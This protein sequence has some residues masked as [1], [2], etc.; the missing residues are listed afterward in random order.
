MFY[1]FVDMVDLVSFVCR[2]YNLHRFASFEEFDSVYN[3]LKHWHKFS[4]YDITWKNS[5]NLAYF[6]L[7]QQS[8]YHSLE[9]GKLDHMI[10]NT[11]SMFHAMELLARGYHRLAILDQEKRMVAILTQSMVCILEICCS[12]KMH[13]VISY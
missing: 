12:F 9:S 3:Q 8:K 1:G 6:L 5:V 7:F 2:N 4:V 10:P 13:S 11:F